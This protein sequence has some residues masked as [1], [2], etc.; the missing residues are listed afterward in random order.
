MLRNCLIKILNLLIVIYFNIFRVFS[1]L[2]MIWNALF[3]NFSH[4]NKKPPLNKKANKKN[5]DLKRTEKEIK[6]NNKLKVENKKIT[7]ELFSNST[8]LLYNFPIELWFNIF[9]YLPTLTLI[10]MKGVCTLF[11][12]LLSSDLSNFSCTNKEII[13]IHNEVDIHYLF[14]NKLERIKRNNGKKKMSTRVKRFLKVIDYDTVKELHKVLF[15]NVYFGPGQLRYCKEKKNQSLVLSDNQLVGNESSYR[16]YFNNNAKREEDEGNLQLYLDEFFFIQFF[17]EYGKY[18]KSIEFIDC[19]NLSQGTLMF[20]TKLCP[21]IKHFKINHCLR[22]NNIG[23]EYIKTSYT[24]QLETLSIVDCTTIDFDI[25]SELLLE[26]TNLTEYQFVSDDINYYNNGIEDWLVHLI[27]QRKEY[28]EKRN[29]FYYNDSEFE[30]GKISV[31]DFSFTTTPIE[32]NSSFTKLKTLDFSYINN[33]SLDLFDIIVLTNLFVNLETL[34]I[35]ISGLRTGSV[36]EVKPFHDLDFRDSRIRKIF[37]MA[38][39]NNSLKHLTLDTTNLYSNYF[40]GKVDL[41]DPNISPLKK[42]MTPLT[43][44]EFM[45]M[46]PDLESCDLIV[47]SKNTNCTFTEKEKFETFIKHH[48]KLR[49]LKIDAIT[50]LNLCEI[51]QLLSIYCKDLTSLQLC[52]C[53]TNDFNEEEDYITLVNAFSSLGENLIH[54]NLDLELHQQKAN[55]IMNMIKKHCVALEELSLSRMEFSIYKNAND[56]IVRGLPLPS[57]LKKLFIIESKVK[58]TTISEGNNRNKKELCPSL[59]VISIQETSN[60]GMLL[61]VIQNVDS[62]TSIR[63]VNCTNAP[64]TIENLTRLFTLNNISQLRSVTIRDDTLY[65]NGLLNY[66][67]NLLQQQ[68]KR[69][70][71]NILSLRGIFSSDNELAILLKSCKENLSVLDI[72][73]LNDIKNVHEQLLCCK[74]LRFCKINNNYSLDN[75]KLKELIQKKPFKGLEFFTVR[76]DYHH[77]TKEDLETLVNQYCKVKSFNSIYDYGDAFVLLD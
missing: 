58:I 44:L 48:K 25:N 12:F 54:F 77:K 18:I 43:I 74:H 49:S 37:T 16:Y 26:L 64:I 59:E 33:D 53:V 71:L 31:K 13:S 24:N 50:E 39:N 8:S 63:V 36:D 70:N 47:S 52:G 15:E 76:Y 22:V 6:Q 51:L 32:L 5:K 40:E 21:F 11:R 34:K 60:T 23:I 20:M 17:Y 62:L 46:F 14:N 68:T 57:K 3:R 1:Y 75:D 9:S 29:E 30:V 56:E 69:N 45:K 42:Y 19:V 41:S 55:K 35:K 61:D 66:W 67:N 38:Q 65:L 27:R 73:A 10:R 7:K 28:H 72:S 2:S 4:N